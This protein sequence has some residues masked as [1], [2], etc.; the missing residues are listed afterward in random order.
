ME[1]HYLDVGCGNMTLILLPNGTTYLYDCNV[2]GDNEDDIFTY[3]R[4]A[5]GSRRRIDVFV[6]SHRDADHMRGI[7]KVHK[8]HPIRRIRD[9]GVP[10]TTVDTTE[11]LE[12]MQL[13]RD[14]SSRDIEAGKWLREGEATI[15]WLNSKGPTTADAN[16]QS[17]VMK[18]EYKDSCALFAGDTTYRPWRDLV[19]PSYADQLCADILLGAHHGSKTF[20]NDPPDDEYTTH[21]ERISP[22]ITI[23]SVGPNS[24]GLPD[25]DAIRLYESYSTWL[26]GPKVL[27]TDERGHIKLTSEGGHQWTFE[28][29]Q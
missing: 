19:L 26:G 24:S 9:A 23:I 2:T 11:Y 7:K 12:Y 15:T 20:F 17:V 29:A 28:T 18:V 22:L 21:I 3:L 8:K 13:R 5:M 6:C 4:K 10:G 1:I 25:D 27:R 14:I 16:D